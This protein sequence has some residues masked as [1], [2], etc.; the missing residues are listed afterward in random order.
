MSEIT[1]IAGPN[2]AGKSTLTKLYKTNAPIIDPDA[3]AREISPEN[4]SS[5]AIAASRLAISRAR[6]FILSDRSF[7]VE[8]TLSGKT[9]LNLMNEVKRLGWLVRLVYI[10]TDHTNINIQRVSSR[11]ELGGHDVPLIDILRRYERSLENL[12]KAIMIADQVVLYDNSTSAG[13]QMIATIANGQLVI[14]CQELP[15]WVSRANLS[16]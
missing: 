16:L 2:G 14:H 9:Y 11:V 5:A 12:H 10:G 7:I 1:I 15:A 13:H 4:P 3:I 6:N 8:T